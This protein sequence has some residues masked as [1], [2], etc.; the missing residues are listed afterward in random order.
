[1][2]LGFF[3]CGYFFVIF[4]LTWRIF[5]VADFCFPDVGRNVFFAEW[6]YFFGA[7]VIFL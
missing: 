2:V 1:V 4:I 5:L 3:R 6:F 7:A